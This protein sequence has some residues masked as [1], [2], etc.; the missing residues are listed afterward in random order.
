[1]SILRRFGVL[2]ALHMYQ[3]QRRIPA[4][5]G[6]RLL[7]HQPYRRQRETRQHRTFQSPKTHPCISRISLQQWVLYSGSFGQL[8]N[9]D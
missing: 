5:N 9:R 3:R 8:F 7:P 4:R 2:P 1:M 6:L